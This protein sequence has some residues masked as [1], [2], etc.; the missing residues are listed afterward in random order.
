MRDCSVY[1]TDKFTIVTA[2]SSQTRDL[3]TENA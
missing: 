2:E 3:I 1:V